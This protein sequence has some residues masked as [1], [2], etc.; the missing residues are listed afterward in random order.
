MLFD[1][2]ESLPGEAKS[3]YKQKMDLIGLKD[4]PYRFPQGAWV[5][6]P[7]KWPELDF[8]D[9]YLINTPGICNLYF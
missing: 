2:F 8:C 7:T 1:Y 6:N 4:C 5:E 9:T 3:R